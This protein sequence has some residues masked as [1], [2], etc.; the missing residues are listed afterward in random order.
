[1]TDQKPTGTYRCFAC[2]SILDGSETYVES[3]LDLERSTRNKPYFVNRITCEPTC[4]ATAMK[5][6]E[7]SKEK[8][9]K[10]LTV[11]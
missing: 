6:S 4:G 11:K 9:L 7:F 10:S 3:N 2:K 5:I 1:M 8:Y